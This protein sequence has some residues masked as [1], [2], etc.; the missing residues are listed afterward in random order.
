VQH[1]CKQLKGC[2]FKEPPILTEAVHHESIPSTN[3]LFDE[4]GSDWSTHS[5]L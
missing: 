2:F 4:W 3:Y 1:I 5:D